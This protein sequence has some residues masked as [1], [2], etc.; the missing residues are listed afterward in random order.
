MKIET[1]ANDLVMARFDKLIGIPMNQRRAKD[2]LLPQLNVRLAL[3]PRDERKGFKISEFMGAAG[4]CQEMDYLISKGLVRDNLIPEARFVE[5]ANYIRI[6]LNR[7]K[8]TIQTADRSGKLRELLSSVEN[9]GLLAPPTIELV[10]SVHNG[11]TDVAKRNPEIALF[12]LNLFNFFT[13]YEIFH[14]KIQ[15]ALQERFLR[16]RGTKNI[17]KKKPKPPKRRLA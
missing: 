1:L 3:V 7:L 17:I 13:Y 14:T 16:E 15:K 11:L 10:Q 12:Q 2:I 9:A 4:S 8:H 6:N 5:A